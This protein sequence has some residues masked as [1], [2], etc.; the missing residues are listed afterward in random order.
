MAGEAGSTVSWY[1]VSETSSMR[2]P[3]R[4]IDPLMRGVAISTRGDAAMAAS[5][6]WV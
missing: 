6:V 4:S 2:P 3:F 1:C 5:R